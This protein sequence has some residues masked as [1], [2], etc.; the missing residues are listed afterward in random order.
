MT[1]EMLVTVPPHE[2]MRRIMVSGNGLD[3]ADVFEGGEQDAGIGLQSMSIMA[4]AGMDEL[5]FGLML[6]NQPLLAWY[7]PRVR[8]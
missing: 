6:L 1:L 2:L 7:L 8:L 4:E 5:R 3:D